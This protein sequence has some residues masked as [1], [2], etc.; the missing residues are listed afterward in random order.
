MGFIPDMGLLL[1]II[2][3]HK[4]FFNQKE[5][6]EQAVHFKRIGDEIIVKYELQNNENKRIKNNYGK[7]GCKANISSD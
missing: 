1:G 2:S 3:E 6:S 5:P 4:H 7:N